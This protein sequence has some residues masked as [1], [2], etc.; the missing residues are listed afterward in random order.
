MNNDKLSKAAALVYEPLLEE[1]STCDEISDDH[2]FS[3]D[4]ERKMSGIISEG[5]EKRRYR[6]KLSWRFVLA[7]IILFAA[8]FCLGAARSPVHDII[9]RFV[10][11]DKDELLIDSESGDDRIGMGAKYVLTDLPEGY[12][13]TNSYIDIDFAWSDYSNGDDILHFAQYKES[14]YKD[15]YLDSSTKFEYISDENGQEYL[16]LSGS[17]FASVIWHMD[18]YVFRLSGNLDKDTLIGLCSKT[19]MQ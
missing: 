19:K 14:V 16:Y 13:L 4:F 2:R 18:G 11:N 7:A 9:V 10:G 17:G 6:K 3:E 15:V 8:G 5:N 1:Y 12:S